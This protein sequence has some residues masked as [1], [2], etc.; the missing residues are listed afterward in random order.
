MRK[1]KRLLLLWAVLPVLCHAQAYPTKPVKIIVPAQPGGGL[2][3]IGRTIGDQLSRA[4]GEQFVI[5]NVGGGGGRSRASR[6]RARRRTA[7]P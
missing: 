6:P 7:T 1:L 3:L 2:D 5:E 4:F